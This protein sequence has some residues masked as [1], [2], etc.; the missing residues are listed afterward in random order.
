MSMGKREGKQ[1]AL[2]VGAGE[3]PRSPG[4]RFYEKLNE[5]LR[6]ADFDR[7]VEAICQR[8]YEKD[9][10]R[11][12]N[13]VWPQT[14]LVIDFDDTRVKKYGVYYTQANPLTLAARAKK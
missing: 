13:L 11:F 5:L 4:H 9:E 6:E 3:L 8:F 7:K 1:Q 10:D 14:K 2:W 12:L